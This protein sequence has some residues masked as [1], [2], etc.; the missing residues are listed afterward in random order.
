MDIEC[1]ELRALQGARKL[2]RER[3]FLCIEIHTSELAVEVI[4]LLREYNYRIELVE[5]SGLSP[6]VPG[7]VLAGEVQVVCTPD[8][9]RGTA[10]G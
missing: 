6:Y 9:G 8:S 4:K 3:P 1:E 2:L 10:Q 5:E 7:E